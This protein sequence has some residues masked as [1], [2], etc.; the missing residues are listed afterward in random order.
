LDDVVP[1]VDRAQVIRDLG[2][3]A[4]EAVRQVAYMQ[5]KLSQL[6]TP[7]CD[8][9]GMT[10]GEAVR[11]DQGLQDAARV[12]PD[13]ARIFGR[14]ARLLDGPPPRLALRA[15]DEPGRL[16][17]IARAPDADLLVGHAVRTGTGQD[18]SWKLR[19]TDI[20][21]GRVRVSIGLHHPAAYEEVLEAAT[22]FMNE[23]G[24]WWVPEA[25]GEDAP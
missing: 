16:E 4:R 25:G 3:A 1:P 5:V 15:S 19:L 11:V 7:D 2:T 10:P 8:A 23:D 18:E 21:G 9:S 17:V 13:V 14:L 24:P 22:R 12:L 20:G 6:V